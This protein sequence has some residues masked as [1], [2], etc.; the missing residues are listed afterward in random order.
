[1]EDSDIE[2]DVHPRRRND[3]KTELIDFLPAASL[4]PDVDL[5]SDGNMPEIDNE[6]GDL[7][8]VESSQVLLKSSETGRVSLVLKVLDK[9][10]SVVNCR[11]EDGYTPLHR[12]AYNGHKEVVKILLQTGA[13]ITARTVDGWQPLHCACRWGKTLFLVFHKMS[14]GL[15][16]IGYETNLE[17][18]TLGAPLPL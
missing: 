15:Q 1:M 2:E 16:A 5:E 17:K 12:A 14:P 10:S 3:D 9:D 4:P 6:E 18:E 11:D 13:D 7:S 8:L